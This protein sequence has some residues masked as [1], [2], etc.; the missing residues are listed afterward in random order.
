METQPSFARFNGGRGLAVEI[1][2]NSVVKEFIKF[3]V[4]EL[5][6]CWNA[7]L[8]PE[9]PYEMAVAGAA[10]LVYLLLKSQTKD[11]AVRL[12]LL[13]RTLPKIEYFC[14]Q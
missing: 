12:R 14:D 10:L 11:G 4:C 2:C 7:A 8:E 13:H 6:K 1:E 5:I 3:C 9:G